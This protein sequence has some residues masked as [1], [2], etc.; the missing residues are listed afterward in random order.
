MPKRWLRGTR[1]L[2]PGEWA[3]R[4]GKPRVVVENPDGFE[5]WGYAEALRSAGYEVATCCGPES[6][7]GTRSACPLLESG[8]C[9]LIDGADVVVSTSSLP[10]IRSILAVLGSRRLPRVVFEAPAPAFD[11][12]R[13]AAG[14]ALFLAC[15][16]MEETLCAS[17][18]EA[19][20]PTTT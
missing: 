12:Y 16:V 3:P 7:E 18:A 9:S 13:A 11:R 2:D 10:E 6:D 4:S 1:T 15:P 8:H 14:D 5:L 20:S 19:L 17:V